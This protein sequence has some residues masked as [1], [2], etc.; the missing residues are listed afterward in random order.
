MKMLK[1]GAF[2][3]LGLLAVACNDDDDNKNT[4]KLSSEE[5]AEM[6]ASSMGQSGFAGSAEQSAEMAD[7]A[8]A[9]GKLQEC[10]YT[11]EGDFELGGTFGQ[12]VFNLSYNY[13][14]ALTCDGENEPQSFTADFDYSGSYNGPRFESEYTGNGDLTITK[15]GEDQ[16][17][18]EINGSYD[19]SGSFATKED[20][21]VSEE[22]Q[23]S[24]DI[25]ADAVLVSKSTGKIVDGSAD[26]SASGSIEGRGSY[27]FDATITFNDDGTATIQV[28][29]DTYK[30]T[31]SSNTVVKV[32]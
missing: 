29:G 8:S 1:I 24:I 23:H 15:L 16:S 6:I 9:S 28:A 22:G 11:N 31:F 19:R 14:V 2:A 13:N 27:S 5:Q 26:V 25:D 10:G 7:N 17:S 20:G 30:L 32:N 3:I 18:F 21:E 4:A 12:I